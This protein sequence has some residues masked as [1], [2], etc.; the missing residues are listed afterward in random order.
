M[1][2]FV[3]SSWKV[4]DRQANFIRVVGVYTDFEQA[5]HIVDTIKMTESDYKNPSKHSISYY[6]SMTVLELDDTYPYPTSDRN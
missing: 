2:V 5:A 1:Q 4:V 3:V 6:G